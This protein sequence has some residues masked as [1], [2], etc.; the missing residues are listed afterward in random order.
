MCGILGG[1]WR[2]PSA[3]VRDRVF[4]AMDALHH[5][6][7]DD[8]GH[9]A[10][11]IADHE[12]NSILH[13]AHTRLSILDLSSAGHQPMQSSC[14]RY[15]VVF[16]GE[17]YNYRE[18]RNE[19]M[20]KGHR[21]ITET[22][23]EV[24]ISAWTEWGTDCLQRFVGMFTFTLHDSTKNI[25]ICARDAF[26]IKP[27]FYFYE[28]G[29]SF[30]FASEMGA[31]FRLRGGKA[32]VNYQRI[33]DYLLHGIQD[34]SSDTFV[35]GAMHLPPA[36]VMEVDLCSGKIN[37]LKPWWSPRIR[38]TSR[39]TFSDA[40][41]HLR[42]LFLSN[43]R[44]HL[45]SD[46]PVGASLSGGIDSSA[47]VCA[48]RQIEPDMPIHTFSYI[49]DDKQISEDAWIDLINKAV[50]ATPHKVFIRPSDL[51]D[52]LT[53][54][55]EAQG[56]PFNST[57][58][59]AQYRIFKEAQASGIPVILEGQGADEI[60]GGYQGYPG[61]RMRS[62]LER[63]RVPA[64]LHFAGNWSANVSRGTKSP[65]RALAGQLLP[66]C[67][68]AWVQ[69]AQQTNGTKAMLG[70]SELLQ[71]CAS[72]ATP[73]LGRRRSGYGPKAKRGVGF[74][75]DWARVANSPTLW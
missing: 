62:L 1:Y 27:F 30:L 43:V 57:S 15:T 65:W 58:I 45:R 59:Y 66:E 48:M 34:S 3:D 11:K 55:I 50:G 70:G 26:G 61:Q 29:S 54:L 17:I 5:R 14:G 23:T 49:A 24:L 63:G 42:E 35:A 47:I 39:L 53:D 69:R 4:L 25:L 6:G 10:F 52:D 46:V 19:L 31:L 18:L 37:E 51:M 22:D 40:A 28:P 7:P 20:G 41:V 36:H 68:H 56:E 12:K 75:T 64:L 32:V 73:D 74:F 16:N 71:R 60:L 72:T 2:N 33:Y 8:R 38:E 9:D 21:F 67:L 44:L 13:L